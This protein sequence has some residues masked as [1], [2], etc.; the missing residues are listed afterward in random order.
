ERRPRSEVPPHRCLHPALCDPLPRLSA[1]AVP[2]LYLTGP[3]PTCCNPLSLHDALPIWSRRP[4]GEHRALEHHDPDLLRLDPQAGRHRS[5]EHTSN[6]S[7]VST[8]YA[9]FCLKKKTYTNCTTSYIPV[10]LL[11]SNLMRDPPERSTW[12]T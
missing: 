3:P 11:R 7:H 10:P 12:T 9:V 8:S 4:A 1:G 5:E 6:S 2:R